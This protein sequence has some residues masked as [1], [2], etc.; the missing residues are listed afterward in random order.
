MSRINTAFKNT[1]I[2]NLIVGNI[3]SFLSASTEKRSS[4]DKAGR[5]F[6]LAIILKKSGMQNLLELMST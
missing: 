5:K 6:L 3:K 2:R 4:M 1:R